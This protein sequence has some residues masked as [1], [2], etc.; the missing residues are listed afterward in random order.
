[1]IHDYKALAAHVDAVLFAE[2]DTKAICPTKLRN[3]SKD[4]CMLSYAVSW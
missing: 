1:M 3:D 4:E 2:S